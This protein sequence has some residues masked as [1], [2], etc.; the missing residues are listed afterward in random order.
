M[1]LVL[2]MQSAATAKDYLFSK[3]EPG[4]FGG[5]LRLTQLGG[6]PKTL[7]PWTANDAS[8]SSYAGILFDGLVTLDPD[9]DEVIVQMA[10]N[11]WVEDGGKKII[12]EMREGLSWTDAEEITADDVCFTWNVLLKDKIAVSSLRDI[13]LVDGVF[14]TVTK[15]GKYK[16]AFETPKTFAP[17]LRNIGIAI[18]PK[19]DVISFFKANKQELSGYGCD[20]D[21][22]KE[23]LSQLQN[24]FSK[25][26]DVNT[27]PKN[28]VSSGA[29]LLEK[30]HPGERIEFKR[31]PNY[32]VKNS[33]GETLPYVD[34]LIY[35]YVSD[36]SADVFKFLAKESH[37]LSVNPENAALIK[38]LE[39][40][41]DYQLHDLGASSGTNFLWF[42]L[43]DRV[44][45]P[46][47]TWF[48]DLN[49][50]KAID[51]AIDRESMVANVFQGLAAPLFSAE[52]LRS[53]YTKKDLGHKRDLEKSRELLK[54]SGFYTK[55]KTLFDRNDEPV[56]FTLFTNSGN[57]ERELMASIIK[58]NLAQLGI[59]V[60]F[61]SLEFNNF[62]G[63]LM[64]GENYQAG[65]I[66]LTGGNE[67]NGGANV[68]K[69]DGRLHLFDVR[70][71]KS[72]SEPRDWEKEIDQLFS[73]GVQTLDFTERKKIYDQ[74]QD[75]VYEKRPLIYLVS[76]NSLVAVSNSLG[77]TR[78]TKYAGLM[79][80]LY[81]IYIR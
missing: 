51:C 57:K 32:Y 11:F 42:N 66:G 3:T 64:A 61:K 22:C 75:I 41:Y 71:A 74:F 40:K 35:S 65:I 8:S 2:V 72:S 69:S 37:Q 48:N 60:N 7:N 44:P 34:K 15:L 33:R 9:T 49:F 58:N 47:R 14:P 26:L 1:V 80:Y 31:N 79:P 13:L 30:I 46:Q 81:E 63:R 68:W 77:N 12:V 52:A 17:F 53:P 18:A 38:S 36:K 62:V 76:P 23:K 54:T 5:S 39:K 27:D 50:R 28:I 59:Q 43:S 55:D 70:N 19:H 20:S 21:A 29:F 25:Y 6:D 10:K 78:K 24:T 73:A 16:V 4:K 56:V 67:P 45:E